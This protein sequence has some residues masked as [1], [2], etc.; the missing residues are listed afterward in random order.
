LRKL[1]FDL[2]DARNQVRARAPQRACAPPRRAP[3]CVCWLL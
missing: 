1:F 3:Q 2:L